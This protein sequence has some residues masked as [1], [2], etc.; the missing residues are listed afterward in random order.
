MHN[1][2]RGANKRNIGQLSRF[3]SSA[4]PKV[5]YHA[6]YSRYRLL[7][8]FPLQSFCMQPCPSCRLKQPRLV[9][10]FPEISL[11]ANRS[12]QTTQTIA[13]RLPGPLLGS[14]L[15]IRA[16]LSLHPPHTPREQND[17]LAEG[18]FVVLS[19]LRIARRRDADRS[20]PLC[21][22]FEHTG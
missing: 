20:P 14:P 11:A 2:V 3:W 10:R 5:Q 18:V 19:I 21:P 22:C 12:R 9:L 17:Q 6:H 15:R 8:D 7:H 4:S 1:P 16:A 13:K